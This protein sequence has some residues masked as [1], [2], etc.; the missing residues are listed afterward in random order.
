MITYT[1]GDATQPQGTGAK[2]I[3]HIVNDRGGFGKGFVLAI[4]AR[5]PEPKRYYKAWHSTKDGFHLGAIQVIEVEPDLWVANMI[6]QRGY[7][8]ANNPTPLQYDALEK[9]LDALAVEAKKL[10]ASIHMPKIGTGLSGGSW[11]RIEPLLEKT[12]KGISV[13]VY[14]L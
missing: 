12:L 4:E 8:S 2:I 1:K 11:A 9:C 13:T 5:W 3:A 14:A 7:R 10:G 6:A